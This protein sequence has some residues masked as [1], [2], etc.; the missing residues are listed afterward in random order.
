MEPAPE[1]V[2]FM[3]RMYRSFASADAQ[4]FADVFSRHPGTRVVG[5]APEEWWLGFAEISATVRVQL[6]EMPT[7]QFRVDEIE[8]WKEGPIG[9]I[10]SKASME[11]QD[12]PAVET[13]STLVLREEGAY[14]RVVQWHISMPVANEATLGVELTTSV[15]ALLA[16]VEGEAPSIAVANAAGE[17][18]IA[19]TDIEG[20]TALMESLGEESWLELLAWHDQC[21]RQQTAL[22]G[23]TIVKHQGDGFMLAF[24]APGAATACAGAIQH[25]L[26]SGWSGVPFAVRMGMHSGNAKSEAGDFFGRTVVV[27][28]RIASAAAGGEILISETV[29]DSVAEAFPL[30]PPRSLT[31]KGLPGEH[32]AFPVIWS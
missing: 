8:A 20:S 7:F 4:A 6:Q 17:I 12:L 32:T 1:L 30:G 29:R 18:T 15:D 19:F 9:W 31:L 14:W 13:R 16:M 24:S 22:F 25:A 21:V 11:I 23:G 3:E 10:A 5:T 27:A 2:V 28:A 26:S